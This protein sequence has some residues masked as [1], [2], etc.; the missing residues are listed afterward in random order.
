MTT[1]RIN[2]VTTMNRARA[3]TERLERFALH[4]LHKNIGVF[5]RVA[6]SVSTEIDNE[7]C[8]EVTPRRTGALAP[9][10]HAAPL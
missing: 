1:G 5:L 4:G 10:G 8:L 3:A 7:N 2:Q 9:H 6:F